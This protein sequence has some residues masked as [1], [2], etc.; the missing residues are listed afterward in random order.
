[1][2]ARLLLRS[3]LPALLV[4]L[5]AASGCSTLAPQ[6]FAGA[7]PTFDPQTFFAGPVRSWGVVESHSGNPKSRFRVELDGVQEGSGLTITQNFRYD[8]GHSEHRVWH[9]RKLD[10]HRFEATGDDVRGVTVGE[11]YGNTF[12][13][14]YTLATRPGNPLFN[15][16][17]HHWMYLVDRDTMI[18]RV[19][20]TKFGV[21]VAQVTEYFHRGTAEMP[22]I[23]GS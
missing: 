15:V 8:D 9:M 4:T 18:N 22:S 21:I 13:W 12:R 11:A 6:R 3:L 1:M 10:E 20:V 19:T 16:Q 5:L 2:N 7:A 23:G 17:M 14:E